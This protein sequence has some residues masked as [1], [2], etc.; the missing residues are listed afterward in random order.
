[1]T[2]YDY[3]NAIPAT[4]KHTPWNKGKLTGA[5]PPFRPKHVWSIRSK[6]QWEGRARDLAMFNVAIDSKLRG[7][8]IVALRVED[9]APNGYTVDRATIRQ[10]KTGQCVRFELTE[11]TR[12]AVDDYLR[13]ASKKAGEFLFAG[14]RGLRRSMTTRQYARLVSEWVASIGLD[15]QNFGG[16]NRKHAF[17]DALTHAGSPD[18][19]ID[20]VCIT[21]PCPRQFLQSSSSQVGSGFTSFVVLASNATTIAFRWRGAGAVHSINS[22]HGALKTRCPLY[23]QKRTLAD[24]TWMSALCQKQTFSLLIVRLVRGR[25]CV[26]A[27]N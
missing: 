13:A 16:P 1:M 17:K 6:L 19:R 5:K 20:L 11:Q 15:P 18:S 26:H 2:M 23:P 12:Q 9:I 24:R 25:L 8:D 4:A 10:R 27:M 14:R 21:S 22:G 7:C 3:E